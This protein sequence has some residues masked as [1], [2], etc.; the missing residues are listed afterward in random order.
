MK[1]G[2]NLSFAAKRWQDPKELADVCASL[3]VKY[4]QFNL[5][6]VDPWWPEDLRMDLARAYREAFAEKGL[7]FDSLFGGMSA[8]AMPQFL[9]HDKRIR[10]VVEVYHARAL[11]LAAAVGGKAL[12]ISVGGYTHRDAYDP[13]RRKAIYDETVERLIRLA[14]HGK[15]QGVESIQVEPVPL[16][17]EFPHG[18]E[19]SLQL[20]KDL[21]GKTDIPVQIFLDWGHM[22]CKP[23]MKEIADM[24]LWIKELRPYIGDMHLQQT[25]GLWDRHWDFRS[26]GIVTLDLIESVLKGNGLENSVQYMEFCPAYEDTDENVYEGVAASIKHLRQIFDE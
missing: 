5:D 8:Y 18:I 17:T 16:F 21:D 26:D 7:G 2:L 6:F 11:E 10:D 22:L 20:M 23:F 13:E 3:G 15:K 19:D 25:D 4:F 14:A 9:A 1:L 24:N 12:G